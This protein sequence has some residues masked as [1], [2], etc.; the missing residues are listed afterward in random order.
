MNK[1]VEDFSV[2]DK[3]NDVISISLNED[4]Q[5]CISGSTG[6]THRVE[7]VKFKHFRITFH[8]RPH[9][10]SATEIPG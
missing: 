7:C 5:G 2:Y 8:E 10:C 1:N 4:T 3:R 6:G 9:C